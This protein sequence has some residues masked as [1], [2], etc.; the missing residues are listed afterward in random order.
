V[1]IT[2]DEYL[3]QV[4]FLLQTER[5]VKNKIRRDRQNQSI[6]KLI[7]QPGTKYPEKPGT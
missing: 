3:H 6:R 7:E 2:D 5:N 4:I 1:T